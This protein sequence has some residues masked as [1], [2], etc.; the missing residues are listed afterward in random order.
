[1]KILVCGLPDSGKTTLSKKIV[2]DLKRINI[3][4][5]YFNADE[6]RAKADDWDFSIDGR[7]R[8][9]KR[10]A[11]LADQAVISGCWAI[12]D[13]VCPTRETRTIF[14]GD[15]V[16]WLDTIDKGRFEDTNQIFQPLTKYDFR[17]R[18]HEDFPWSTYII[19]TI[20]KIKK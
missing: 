7:K 3:P 17:I 10:M 19:D 12:C 6:E 16:V 1:M 8:Q 2:E 18:D 9:A 5:S 20:L 11:R 15:F 4:V 14:S 13:F